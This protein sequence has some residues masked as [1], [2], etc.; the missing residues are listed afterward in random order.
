MGKFLIF[1]LIELN[2]LF[3]LHKNHWH[4]SCKFQL[5]ITMNIKVIAKKHLTNLYEIHRRTVH[6][7]DKYPQPAMNKLTWTKAVLYIHTKW[8]TFL[9]CSLKSLQNVE[10]ILARNIFDPFILP[11]PKAFNSAV[12]KW[13]KQ[14]ACPV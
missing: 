6:K 9:W 3:W 2:F 4:R 7:W 14:K 1:G 12:I 10:L 5:E 11:N 13:S 8:G